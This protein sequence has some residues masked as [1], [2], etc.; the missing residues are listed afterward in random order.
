MRTNTYETPSLG[1]QMVLVRRLLHGDPSSSCRLAGTLKS[2]SNAKVLVRYNS[3]LR[4]CQ[5]SPRSTLNQRG[6]PALP[7]TQVRGAK[8]KTTLKLRELPQ[9]AL[10]VDTQDL[11]H[12]DAAPEYPTVLQ[13]ARNNMIKFNH[14]VLLTRVGGFYEVFLLRC[15]IFSNIMLILVEAVFRA[16]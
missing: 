1:M 14:A 13:Q 12:Q 7:V 6:H 2:R 9:G 16:C 10:P 3:S 8:I 5:P 11:V 15:C 4:L